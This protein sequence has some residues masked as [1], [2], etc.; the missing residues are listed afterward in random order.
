MQPNTNWTPFREPIGHTL[1]RNIVIAVVVG[2]A[3]ALWK[4]DVRLWAP[5][6]ALAIWFS[7]GGHHVE[8]VFL[9][10]IRPQI[11]GARLTQLLA[12][13]AAWFAGGA[14]LYVFMAATARVLL[15]HP[16]RFGLWWLGGLI[17]IGVELVAHS[18]LALRGSSS[19]YGVGD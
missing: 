2:G 7:L 9:N 4:R 5:F 1:A 14:I 10:G 3:L 15:T 16:P 18:V 13:L 17:M 8:V 6:S 11:P 12:R 19:F